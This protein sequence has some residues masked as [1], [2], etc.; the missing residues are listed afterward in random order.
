MKILDLNLL[1]YA[2][3][4]SAAGHARARA[5]LEAAMNGGDAVGLPW[6]VILGFLRLATN[7]RVFPNPL[8][9]ETAVA[10]VDGWLSCGNVRI[11]GERPG[12]WDILKTFV[13]EHGIAGNLAT[14]AH[15]AAL[16][17]GHDAVLVTTD[18]DFQ[19][20]EGL[21]IEHPLRG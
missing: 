8:A 13:V 6:V 20:F 12:H 9:P 3:N 19:R 11:V 16:A 21:R 10:I 15:L 1:L 2:V 7:S 14:D 17:L 4:A 5:W 18:T